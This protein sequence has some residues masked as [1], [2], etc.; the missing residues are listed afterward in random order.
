[1]KIPRT[2]SF[3]LLTSLIITPQTRAVD[4]LSALAAA[5]A[6][7]VIGGAGY[8]LYDHSH[9]NSSSNCGDALDK[10]YQQLYAE[11]VFLK[12]AHADSID[13]LMPAYKKL[14]NQ[15]YTY[16]HSLKI[17]E[18]TRK[19]ESQANELIKQ[20][21]TEHTRI[22]RYAHYHDY[23]H[24][25]KVESCQRALRLIQDFYKNLIYVR[26][27]ST[28][29]DELMTELHNALNQELHK[30]VAYEPT[31]YQKYPLH[32]Y[33]R[34]LHY[35]HAVYKKFVQDNHFSHYG[36]DTLLRESETLLK[37]VQKSAE[38][39]LEEKE[40]EIERLKAAKI[41]LED[42]LEIQ[43]RKNNSLRT[44]NDSLAHRNKRLNRL[45]QE[46]KEIRYCRECQPSITIC[47]HDLI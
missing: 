28:V 34:K 40:M 42:D 19:I 45:V 29:K 44:E 26:D 37:T 5:A 22:Q 31:S 18:L 10:F 39:K 36:T 47:L 33:A 27:Y 21:V 25:H 8:L 11:N 1:M 2:T 14:L 35:A 46:L 20:L 3:F 12:A 17:S 6:G 16:N 13:A 24:T 38:Y 9:Y 15:E 32:D 30:Q 7:A 43:R 41:A 4:P 23:G